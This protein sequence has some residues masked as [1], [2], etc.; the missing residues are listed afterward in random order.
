MTCGTFIRYANRINLLSRP[1]QF[2][3]SLER[4]KRIVGD[5]QLVVASRWHAVLR[6]HGL[7]PADCAKVEAA[8]NCAELELDPTL[9]FGQ[10]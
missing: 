6:Q 2:K 9:V 8:F 10:R 7:T 3:L 5:V 1:G 4:A